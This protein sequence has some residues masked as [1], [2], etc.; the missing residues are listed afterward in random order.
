MA[1]FLSI[2]RCISIARSILYTVFELSDVEG[3]YNFIVGF[4]VPLE[5]THYRLFRSQFYGSD[6]PTNQ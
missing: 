5:S 1:E 4:I 2:C 3:Y 6:D